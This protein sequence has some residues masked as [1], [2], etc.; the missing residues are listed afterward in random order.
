MDYSEFFSKNLP[1]KVEMPT[2][3]RADTTHIFSVTNAVPQ[4]IDPAKYAEAMS[5]VL[6]REARSLAGYPGMKGHEGLRGV[7]ADELKDKRGADGGHRRHLPER[8]RGRRNPQA[9]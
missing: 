2:G 9:G 1:A 5:N 7:I 4:A 3:L 6:A 8:R